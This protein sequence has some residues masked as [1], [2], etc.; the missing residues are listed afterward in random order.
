MDLVATYL[1]R[2]P[3]IQYTQEIR[4]KILKKQNFIASKT[5]VKTVIFRSISEK[6]FSHKHTWAI[7]S[8]PPSQKIQIFS[9]QCFNCF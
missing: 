7:C 1:L 4:K 6:K 3:L 9:F 5:L 2:M 8:L